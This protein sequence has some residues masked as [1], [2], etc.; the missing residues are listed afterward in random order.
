MLIRLFPYDRR[1]HSAAAASILFYFPVIFVIVK[2]IR[3][4]F[5][6]VMN[7]FHMCKSSV[8]ESNSVDE[9][10]KKANTSNCTRNNEKTLYSPIVVVVAVAVDVLFSGLP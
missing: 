9:S 10:K 6:V 1:C 3:L 7:S 8:I 5:V 4:D 2:S